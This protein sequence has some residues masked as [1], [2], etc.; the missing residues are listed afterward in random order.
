MK[1]IVE[2]QIMKNQEKLLLMGVSTDTPYVL[3]YAKS[4]GV[5]TII[6]DNRS[7]EISKEKKRSD[8]YWMID[9][10][11][12]DQLEEMCR[13]EQI[14]GIYAGNN[15]FCLDQTKA[16][17]KRLSLPFYA[18]DEGWA[19]S[20]D[21]EK[22][23]RYCMECGLDVPHPYWVS[24]EEEI[25]ALPLSIFPVIVKPVDSC[26][27]RGLF[28]CQNH[29]ELQEYFEKARATSPTGRV[30]VEAYIDGQ[31]VGIHYFVVDST[32]FLIG[33]ED[34]LNLQIAERKKGTLALMPSVHFQEYIEQISDKVKNLLQKMECRNGNV[35]LQAIYRNGKFYFL[36]MGYRL[37][38]TALWTV[39]EAMYEFN[40]LEGMVD[41]ALGRQL[42]TQAERL[43]MLQVDQPK[44][45]G[46]SYVI[47]AK[48]GIIARIEGRNELEQLIPGTKI[49][50]EKFFVGDRISK[51]N[52]MDQIP[53]GI[54]IF[55]NSK[56]EI[57]EKIDKINQI[58]HVYDQEGRDMLIPYTF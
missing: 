7:P 26:A 50:W 29:Q 38:G 11:D 54:N 21:K 25:A 52:S 23:K 5:F 34:I 14:T 35:F 37:E 41:L 19:C 30:I 43:N 33:S 4:L 2:R 39:C 17:C 56:D 10:K 44:K 46:A 22:F 24:S 32:P 12:L 42:S 40:P 20:R 31:E 6:T 51:T 45:W 28:L 9:L 53:Y 36:E 48:P 58:L 13:A 57:K 3:S 47:W 27:Q 49:V 15:E 8:A 1:K 18:S 16:L 55:A